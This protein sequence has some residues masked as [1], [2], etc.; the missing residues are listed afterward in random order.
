MYNTC[1]VSVVIIHYMYCRS[2]HKGNSHT[3]ITHVHVQC[4]HINM[5]LCVIYSICNYIMYVCICMY[6]CLCVYIY[7]CVCVCVC[8]S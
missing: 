2:S 7:V 1:I 8:H 5:G 3:C 6:V 4:E